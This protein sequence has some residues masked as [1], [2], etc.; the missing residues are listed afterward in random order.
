MENKLLDTVWK[1]YFMTIA[2]LM[3]YFI[4]QDIQ[5]GLFITFR[6]AFAIALFASTLLAFLIKP[7]IA[8]GAA[9]LK[10]T[11]VYCMPLL[12]TIIMSLFIWFSGHVATDIIARGLSNSFI[13]VN[14]ISFALAA[15]SFLYVFGEKGIWYNLLA[16]VISNVLMIITIILQNGIASF[17]SE[18]ITLIV[19][20]A[21]VTGNI[22]V[23]AEIHEL[24]FCIGAYMVY[25]LLKPK[26]K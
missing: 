20:F 21:D 13:Y 6:H 19:T 18:F 26:K 10:A 11:L 8:R 12:V 14:M 5:V 22:I 15:V 4:T 25:M 7:N 17:M 3:Y 16:I 24:A 1:I 23:Q 2:V 9:T